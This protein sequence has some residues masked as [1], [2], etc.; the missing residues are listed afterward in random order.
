MMQ[1]RDVVVACADGSELSTKAIVAGLALVPED[2][3]VVLVTVVE[4]VDP[5]LV[6]GTGLAG[7][8]ITPETFDAL[9]QDQL[10]SGKQAVAAVAADLER[11]DVET[12]VVIGSPGVTICDLAD[13]LSARAIVIGTRGRGGF[14]RAFL[15]SVS[16]HVVRNAPCPVIVTGA[17]DGSTDD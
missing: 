15:G 5:T 1:T 16:D 12:R 2:W 17:H 4:P 14:K 13:E 6:S 3:H 7:G 11:S 9:A 8:T 10:D